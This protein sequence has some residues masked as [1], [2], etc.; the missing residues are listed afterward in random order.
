VMLRWWQLLGDENKDDYF[1]V[2][3]DVMHT[4]SSTKLD[5]DV[6]MVDKGK[7]SLIDQLASF[8]CHVIS[9]SAQ[10]LSRDMLD[11]ILC[12]LVSWVQSLEEMIGCVL[13]EEN[14]IKFGCQ[15]LPLLHAVT[16]IFDGQIE[17]ISLLDLDVVTPT[18]HVGSSKVEFGKCK[19]EEETITEWQEF[20]SPTLFKSVYTAFQKFTIREG[21]S[22]TPQLLQHIC[23]CLCCIPSSLLLEIIYDGCSSDKQKRTALSKFVETIAELLHE[24]EHYL[25]IVAFQLL[26]RIAPNIEVELCETQQEDEEK[27][28]ARIFPSCLSSTMEK[29]RNETLISLSSQQASIKTPIAN[30]QDRQNKSSLLA[31]LLSWQLILRIFKSA[32]DSNRAGFANYF[33]S[34][35]HINDLMTCLFCVLPDSLKD[36]YMQNKFSLSVSSCSFAEVQ[37][38]AFQVF[39]SSLESIPA[40]VRLWFNN[41]VDRK[42][43]GTVSKFIASYASPI[44]L[45]NEFLKIEQGTKT[46]S[47]MT[48]KTRRGAREIAAVYTIEEISMELIVKLADNH[49]LVPV[50]VDCGK[51]IGV[52]NAQW[53]QWMLQLA[54]FL[55]WQNGTILDGLLLWKKNVDK[56]FEGVEECMVCFSV[57]HGS[58]YSLPSI[59]CKTCKKKFHAQCLYK[60]FSTSNKS[61]CPLCRNIF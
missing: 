14:L 42:D 26:A 28:C 36:D 20:F 1:E 25:Q 11:N 33:H 51:R 15:V 44:L 18:L 16:R 17:G 29:S 47:N 60:W 49:P 2:T 50:T 61:T 53:R 56:R 31:Y 12:C 3:V 52:S 59:A 27:E 35:S 32:P 39:I 6:D 19:I 40:L 55:S 21:S 4:I 13:D 5:V 48:V 8:M 54:R 37:R 34:N 30:M 46:F 9:V 57:I 10:V 7:M 23:L 45:Q 38:L 58:N 22:K 41:D 24:K 43:S